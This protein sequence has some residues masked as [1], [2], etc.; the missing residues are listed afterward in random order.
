MIGPEDVAPWTLGDVI[1]NDS[2]GQAN[3]DRTIGFMK[4]IFYS[5]HPERRVHA[6]EELYSFWGGAHMD[7]RRLEGDSEAFHY[8]RFHNETPYVLVFK[9]PL[10]MVWLEEEPDEDERRAWRSK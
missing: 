8:I 4:Q 2:D 3:L 10:G 1:A 6:R 7:V 5:R 9:T